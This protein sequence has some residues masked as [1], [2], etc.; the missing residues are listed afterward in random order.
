M[1]SSENED[2]IIEGKKEEIKK[3][4]QDILDLGAHAAK[5][6]SE[7]VEKMHS[8]ISLVGDVISYPN[9][10]SGNNPLTEFA[11]NVF[12]LID[13]HPEQNDSIMTYLKIFGGFANNLAD[14]AKEKKAPKT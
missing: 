8:V 7:I 9:T 10:N 3:L 4:T 13:S 6:R 12:V 11:Q 2:A 5:N 14:A 1:D